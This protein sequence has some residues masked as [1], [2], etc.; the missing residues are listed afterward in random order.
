VKLF[1][2]ELIDVLDAK[3]HFKVEPGQIRTDQKTFLK[4]F[5]GEGAVSITALQPEGKK[6]METTDFLRG[7]DLTGCFFE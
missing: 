2:S 6:R 4:V 3:I 7:R 5:C 1:K